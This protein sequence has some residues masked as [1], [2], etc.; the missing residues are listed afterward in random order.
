MVSFSK[1]PKINYVRA[2]FHARVFLSSVFAFF[3]FFFQL[4]LF[5]LFSFICSFKAKQ[6]SCCCALFLFRYFLVSFRFLFPPTVHRFPS[7]RFN[8]L[9]IH[10]RVGSFY[11][12][13]FQVVF[14]FLFASVFLLF[15]TSFISFSPLH[16]TLK[17]RCCCCF[18]S[19]RFV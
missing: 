2:K 15:F 12:F 17:A 11:L 10:F 4:L 19:F 7:P 6:F 18:L 16:S 1:D 5:C 14:L 13:T 3:F 8:R 9:A